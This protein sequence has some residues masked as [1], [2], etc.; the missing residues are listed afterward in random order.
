MHHFCSKNSYEKTYSESKLFTSSYSGKF[1]YFK[2][3]FPIVLKPPKIKVIKK[4]M[5]IHQMF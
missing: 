3:I 1:D 5:N 2:V 4:T